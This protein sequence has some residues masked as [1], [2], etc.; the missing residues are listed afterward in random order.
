MAMT[1]VEVE[2]AGPTLRYTVQLPGC[3]PERA[4]QAFTSPQ[5]LAQWW[6]NAELTAVLEPDGTYAVW[7]PGIPARMAGQVIRFEPASALEFSWSWEHL[8]ERPLTT[9]AVQVD[10]AADGTTLTLEHGPHP[11]DEQGRLAMTEHRE[12]WAY[13]LPRLQEALVASEP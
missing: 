12:G 3:T 2:D 6:G 10:A 11:D 4:L 13:F 7:F 8:P 1:T 5:M 9:V